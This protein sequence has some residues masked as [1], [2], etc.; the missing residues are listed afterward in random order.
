MQD[1]NDQQACGAGAC[2]AGC[3]ECG[4]AEKLDALGQGTP[5][6]GERR[7]QPAR[8]RCEAFGGP[9]SYNVQLDRTC[10]N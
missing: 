10:A 2:A 7:T 6:G 5:S 9:P 4:E 3:A 8:Q 1:G